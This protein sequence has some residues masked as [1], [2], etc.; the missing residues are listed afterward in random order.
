MLNMNNILLDTG[1]WFALYDKNDKHYRSA[2]KLLD[3]FS[4]S[5]IIIPYPTLY[6]TVINRTPKYS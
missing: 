6:E 4:Y 2:E 5:Q 3:Y 1:F